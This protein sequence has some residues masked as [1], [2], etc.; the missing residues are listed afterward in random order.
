MHE[1]ERCGH[2]PI[3]YS[4]SDAETPFKMII[5][6]QKIAKEIRLELAEKISKS[7]DKPK[8]C[9]ILVGKNPASLSY[10]GRKAKACEE[11]G[12]GY[13]C[14]EF[15]ESVT[16]N[17][18]LSAIAEAN[19]DTTVHGLI[20]QLPLPSHIRK[21]KVV[22]A[23]DP[24]KDV[25][26]FTESNAGKC[27]LNSKDGLLPC[28]PKGVVRLLEKTGIDPVGKNVTVVGYGDIVGKP[29]SIMLANA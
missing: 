11:I 20:V 5:D 7:A 2:S 16:E 28:T 26:G 23:V 1:F 14:L 8:L 10:V 25:D 21:E 24:N 18:L 3:L 29:L 13:E 12:M 19:A 15:D 22:A 6:G 17:E 9:V 4:L 27:F